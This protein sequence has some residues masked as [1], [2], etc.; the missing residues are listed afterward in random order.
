VNAILALGEEAAW[1]G[2]LQDE[3]EARLGLGLTVPVV[4]I[5][6][7]LWHAPPIILFGYNYP[8]HR[9][10]VGV[11]AF[12]VFCTV[13]SA[14]LALLKKSSGSVV[15]PAVMHGT[16]NA[17]GSL[18]ALSLVVR[19]ELLGMPV[20]LLGMTSFALVAAA[21]ALAIYGRRHISR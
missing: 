15:P 11:A 8:H 10:L 14:S 5:L 21:L 18:M 9:D 19:D 7:A 2:L 4:G 16:V 6:W 20:G 3:L 17:L 1:R 12:M 13:L